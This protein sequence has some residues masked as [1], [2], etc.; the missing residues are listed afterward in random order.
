MLLLMAGGIV[1]GFSNDFSLVLARARGRGPGR[2]RGAA[3]PGHHHPARL[4]AERAGP[5]QRHLRHGR[6]AGA[7]HRAEHRR[8]AGRP[9]RLALDLLH[10]GA[11][12]PGL[13]VAGLEVRA[14]HRA[15]RRRR[16][17]A[18]ARLDWRGLLLGSVGTLCLLN[19]LVRAARRRRGLRRAAAGAAALSLVAF[20]AWQRRLKARG[21]G[22]ADG[23]RA[24]RHRTFAMGSIVAFIYGT[25]LFGSTYLLPVYMQLALGL[26]ASY[27]G[28]ILLPAG[29]VLAVTIAAGRAAGRP[30]A[31]PRAGQHR[32][33]AAGR[34][35]R[36]DGDHRPGHG[37]LGAGGLGHPGAHRAGLH[38]AVAQPRL[39]ALA[40]QAPDPA[41]LERDQFPAHAG[42]RGGRE[43][44]RHRAG[45]A[46]RRARRH[47]G[48][49]GHQRRRGWPR[50]TRCSGCWRR[51]ARWPWWP[52]GSCARPAPRARRTV[53]NSRHVPAA[54]DELQH[55][56]RRDVQLHGI[57]PARRAHRPP[58]R[59][60]G[61]RLL[62]GRGPA[63][64]RRPPAGLRV[65]GGRADPPLPDQE[66]QRHRPHPQ[67][68]AG[69]GGAGKLPPF[70]AR[71][72][73]PLLGVRAQRQPGGF[74]SA[75]ARRA[76]A[77]WA[78]PTA[79]ARSAG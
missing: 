33:G 31:H 61:H 21:G 46:H 38:P 50:S 52:P 36:A 76:S 8:R 77:R 18:A 42:R 59:R 79:S 7:G 5:R 30:A 56:H 63:P 78:P 35:L 43:P 23:P 40:G 15:G 26:S 41:G 6:G 3:D 69:R 70:R 44:V 39:D 64:F 37:H 29:F 62:R 20:V 28:T 2:G 14:R 17:S 71:A 11:V 27:V 65:A 48:R 34:F 72:V 45:V 13:A 24:V 9:V 25:A 66:P 10:G 75:P 51:C 60:L 4:R 68:H 19:G 22:A 74:P 12:L 58:R 54:R 55:A 57:R 73:G 49:P 53:Q 67:G 47:A 1:G 32:A 16:P